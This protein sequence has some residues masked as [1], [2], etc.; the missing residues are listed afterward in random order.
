MPLSA[1][2]PRDPIHRRHITCEGFRRADG[3]VEIDGH[4]TD[5]RPFP[6]HGYW[7]W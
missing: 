7:G 6:F 2:S 1:P 4:I 5:I 3:L